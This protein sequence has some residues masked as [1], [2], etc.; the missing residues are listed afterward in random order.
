[1]T[2]TRIAVALTFLIATDAAASARA[3]DEVPADPLAEAKAGKIVCY[4]PEPATRQC[5]GIYRYTWNSDGS[6]LMLNE[7]VI[8]DSEGLIYRMYE[9]ISV[10]DG[11]ICMPW[12]PEAQRQATYRR[13]GVAIDAETTAR[14]NESM[15]E[16]MGLEPG[17]L[18]CLIPR[19]EGDQWRNDITTDGGPP[20]RGTRPYVWVDPADGWRLPGD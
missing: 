4:E 6:I 19:R 2:L 1:M 7:G 12:D 16:G 20:E 9:R 15:V 13:A 17:V 11:Q 18:F 5:S 8:R 14:M 10:V 3:A